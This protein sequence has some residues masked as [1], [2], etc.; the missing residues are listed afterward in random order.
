LN[1]EHQRH[2]KIRFRRH[3]ISN[4][5]AM[6]SAAGQQAHWRLRTLR[7][8]TVRY[9]LAAMAGAG[10]MVVVLVGIV[11]T[12]VLTG[13]GMDSLR[14]RAE[15]AIEAMGTVPLDATIGPTR[16]TFDGARI[17]ALELSDVRVKRADTGQTMLEAGTVRFGIRLLPLLTGQ[18]QLG[19]A[20]VRDATVDVAALPTTSGVDWTERLRDERGLIDPDLVPD[21]LFEQAGALM[22]LVD[23]GSSRGLQLDKVALLVPQGGVTHRVELLTGA[24]ASNVDDRMA[25][26]ATIAVDGR[27]VKLAGEAH[28]GGPSGRIDSLELTLEGAELPA[29]GGAGDSVSQLGGFSVRV[30]GRDEPDGDRTQL[31]VAAT[32]EKSELDLGARGKFSGNMQLDATLVQGDNKLEIDRLLLQTGRNSFEFNGAFG[33]SPP[34]GAAGEVPL[35]RYELVSTR[36]VAAPEESPEAP[37]PFGMKVAGTFDQASRRMLA[38]EIII[39]SGDGRATG[40]AEVDFVAGLAPGIAF[41]LDVKAMQAAHMKQLWPWFAANRARAWVFTKVFGGTVEQARIDMKVQ[42]G[43]LGNGVP[44]SGEEVSATFEITDTRFDTAGQLPPVRDADGIVRIEGND[45]VVTMSRGTVFLPSGRSV[46]GTNGTLTAQRVVGKPMIGKLEIDVAGEA[47][48]LAELASFDPINAMRRID[49]KPDEFSGE[50]SGHVIADIPFQK[51]TDPATL[52]WLVSLG[53][54]RLAVSREFDGQKLT[55]ADGTL[56]VWPDRAEINAKGRLNG[57]PAELSIVEPLRASG[58]ERERRVALILDDKARKVIAPGLDGLVTGPV[59]VA[60]DTKGGKRQYRADLTGAKLDLPW[61]GWSKGAGVA[62]EA[63]FSAPEGKASEVVLSNFKLSGK[64]FAV[65]GSLTLAGGSLASAR[66]GKVQLNRGDSVAVDVRR[67]GKAYAVSVNG[68]SLDA[69]PIIKKLTSSSGGSEGGTPVALKMAVQRVSGFNDEVMTG[70]T[71]SYA[72]TGASLGGLSL[73]AVTGSGKA[74]TASSADNGATL[75]V[76]SSD[77]GAVLRFLDIYRHVQGGSLK[78][79]LA[80][81]GSSMTGQIDARDFW[82]VNEPKLAS[83]VS[84]PTPDTGRSLNE[85]VRRDIDTSKVKFERGYA[86]IAKGPG[87]L[88]LANG[89]LRGPLIG[90]TFQGTLYDPDGRMDMTGTFMPAYGL[91]RIFGELPLIG[92]ILGNGRDRGLI[93]VTYRLE[94]DAKAPRLQIN[95]L[96]VIAPG[97]FRSIFEY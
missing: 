42:P 67:N 64:T 61:V 33:P 31:K 93:G 16:L 78:I 5:G 3:E 75:E 21:A 87:S 25:L 86:Q 92:I 88:K 38:D 12:V 2:E 35:Y 55:E 51:G 58:P 72:G 17:M 62:A 54:K 85:A 90:S 18:V 44:L 70:V 8:R 29:A 36:T 45:I 60:L 52:D 71:L 68:P 37:L 96:S 24:I 65:E 56:T 7:R 27:E 4:L 94:G 66:F 32:L 82:V 57:V 41:S 1:Q 43:R 22:A 76:A 48:A 74:L 97:I 81:K 10:L 69:R 59:K 83:I 47:R 39:T 79:S 77:G 34:S 63:T 40:K 20:R 13:V 6:P 14:A 84:S 80:G 26:A 9:C 95:P 53:F 91:N 19:G 30:T 28:R 46:V 23:K 89:V 49:M 11:A 15:D 50:G 73:D